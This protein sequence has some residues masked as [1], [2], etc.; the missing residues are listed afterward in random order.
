MRSC[1][2]TAMNLNMSFSMGGLIVRRRQSLGIDQRTLSQLS[3]VAVHT[4]SNIES[5]KGNP[6]VTTLRRIL[7][8]LG[9]ELQVRVSQE[10]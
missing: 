10:R 3:H 1:I 5:G 6:T 7:E 9:M 4:L 8:V 2:F